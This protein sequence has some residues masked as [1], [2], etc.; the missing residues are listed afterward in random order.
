MAEKAE[1]TCVA[2]PL[3]LDAGAVVLA[4]L[5]DGAGLRLAI[6]ASGGS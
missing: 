1:L 4:D 6:P 3:G 5:A 2:A